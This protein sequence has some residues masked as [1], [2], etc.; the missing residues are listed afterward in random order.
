MDKLRLTGMTVEELIDALKELP[1]TVEVLMETKLSEGI[2]FT[3]FDALGPIGNDNRI[4]RA[5][6]LTLGEA[7]S[8]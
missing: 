7:V 3:V 2:W 1:Q 4:D 6:V 5:V 8:D